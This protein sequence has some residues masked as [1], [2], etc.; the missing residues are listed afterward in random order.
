VCKSMKQRP[1]QGGG[2]QSGDETASG[3]VS[4]SVSPSDSE[5][6]HDS[7]TYSASL[8]KNESSDGGALSAYLKKGKSCSPSLDI[9]QQT[10]AT[11]NIRAG[12]RSSS[13]TN[14]YGTLLSKIEECKELHIAI[15]SPDFQHE[16]GDEPSFTEL[17]VFGNGTARRVTNNCVSDDERYLPNKN[18]AKSAIKVPSTLKSHQ[19]TPLL[20]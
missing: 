3:E 1:K 6:S 15:G 12:V 7:S 20:R 8:D 10:T 5:S 14:D 9:H 17:H 11:Q 2:G 19:T 4:V 16:E 18:K 13:K